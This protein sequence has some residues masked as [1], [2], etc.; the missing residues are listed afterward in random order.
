[1]MMYPAQ[2][3]GDGIHVCAI[4]VE[5]A[6]LHS[7]MR[8]CSREI[9]TGCESR[10]FDRAIMTEVLY[11]EQFWVFFAGVK[12]HMSARQGLGVDVKRKRSL[13]R[14]CVD[15]EAVRIV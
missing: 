7:E 5:L 13:V 3:C 12:E 14:L 9:E 6:L 10:E 15:L 1:M 2:S 11:G 4:A 8:F